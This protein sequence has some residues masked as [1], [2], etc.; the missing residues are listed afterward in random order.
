MK[1]TSSRTTVLIAAVADPSRRPRRRGRSAFNR[2]G[3]ALAD[4]IDATA[5]RHRRAGRDAVTHVLAAA[6]GDPLLNGDVD[7][8]VVLIVAVQGRRSRSPCCSSA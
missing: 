7:L 2:P 3:T 8:A 1:V 4:L 5:R 6:G